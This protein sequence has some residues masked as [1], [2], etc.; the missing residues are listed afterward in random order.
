MKRPVILTFRQYQEGEGTLMDPDAIEKK[1]ESS[2]AN[3]HG[4]L[5]RT[6][7]EW[8]RIFGGEWVGH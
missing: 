4:P 3:A 1:L 5:G 6:S 7:A 8:R 2:N